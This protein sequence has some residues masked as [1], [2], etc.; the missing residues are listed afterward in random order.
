M[1]K[2]KAVDQV[3]RDIVKAKP[4]RKRTKSEAQAWYERMR[5]DYAEHGAEH[6]KSAQDKLKK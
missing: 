5:A 6:L 4:R 3:I 2:A 1:G